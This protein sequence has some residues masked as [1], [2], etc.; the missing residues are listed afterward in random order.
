M[1]FTLLQTRNKLNVAL[2]EATN[3]GY[4]T[5][6]EKNRFIQDALMVTAA[7]LQYKV[8]TTNL[9]LRLGITHYLCPDDMLVPL[10]IRYN[11]TAQLQNIKLFPADIPELEEAMFGWRVTGGGEPSRFIF[12]SCDYVQIW[13]PPGTV[14]DG[15]SCPFDYVPVPEQMDDDSDVIDAPLVA[16]EATVELAAFFA[17]HKKDDKASLVWLNRWMQRKSQAQADQDRDNIFKTSKMRPADRYNKAHHST[18][19]RRVFP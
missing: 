16:V 18:K 3:T 8:K 13:P 15:V 5:E 4:W 2:L 7:E 6:D 9:T 11:P 10:R 17:L 1:S 12:R 19:F 14:Q